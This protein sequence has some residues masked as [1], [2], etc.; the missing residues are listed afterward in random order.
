M[1]FSSHWQGYVKFAYGLL[2]PIPEIAW[3]L[4]PFMRIWAGI[5]WKH[6]FSYVWC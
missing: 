6:C 3:T 5:L 1:K 4:I 2:V